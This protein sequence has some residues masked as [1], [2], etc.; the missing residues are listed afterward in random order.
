MVKHCRD[1]GY[2]W[3]GDIKSKRVVY[4]RGEEFALSDLYDLLC[5]EG[6]FVDV[7]VGGEIYLVCGVKVYVAEIGDVLILINV[8]AGTNDVHFLCSDLVELSVFEFLEMALKRH[9][10]EAVHKEVRALGLGEYQ[11]QRSEAALIHVHPGMSGVCTS[12][13]FAFTSFALWN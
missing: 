4:Y 10:I 2:R 5:E 7:V 3:I 9:V 1:K 12:L 13:Y 11:F 6:W 8:K